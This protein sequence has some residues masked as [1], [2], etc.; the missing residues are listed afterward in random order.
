MKIPSNE[1]I[2]SRNVSTG[3]TSKR[4]EHALTSPQAF[5]GYTGNTLAGHTGK[6]KRLKAKRRRAGLRLWISVSYP[7]KP[8]KMQG[9]MGGIELERK[10]GINPLNIQLGPPLPFTQKGFGI[11]LRT[12]FTGMCIS[13]KGRN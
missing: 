7:K 13:P 2:N 4:R 5:S 1:G 6:K 9:K 10:T 8:T 11:W 12:C 3:N